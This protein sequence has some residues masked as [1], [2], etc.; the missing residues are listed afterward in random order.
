MPLSPHHDESEYQTRRTR[1]DPQ[2]TAQGWVIVPF[3]APPAPP[4][5]AHH[6]VT[7]YPTANGPADY[8]LFVAGQPLGIV[9]AKK[10]TLGPQNVLIQAERYARG[11]A[12][13][14]FNFGGCRAP[15]L[16]STN[17]DAIWFHDV[18]HLLNRSRRV[19][20]FHTPAALQE[21]LARD[22][23]AACS[24]FADTPNDNP[25]LRPYQVEANAAIEQA[26]AGRK[27][28]MLV[29]MAT[30][31]GKT[32]TLVNQVYR[33]MKSGVARRILFLVDR[34]ALA[35]QAVNAFASFEPE[36][37]LKFD[38]IYEVYSQR[39]RREDL[40]DDAK[41][42]A[43]ALP[44]G[45]LLDPQPGHAF[46]YVCTIQRMA[47]NLFGRQAAFAL[48]DEEADDDADRLAIPIHAFDLIVA[49]ECH[50]GYTSAELS[51]WRNTLEHFDAIK[52]GLT[53]TPAAH[54]KAYFT[55]IIYR[56][57]YERAVREGYLVDFDAVAIKSDVRLSGVF[58][59]EGEQV[60]LIDPETGSEL[61]DRLEDERA[62]DTT[63]IERKVT[64]PDSNR[65]IIEEVKKY[66]LDHEQRTGRFPKTLIFAA[67]DVP[68]VSH[69]DQ[70]VNLCREAFGRGDSFVQKITGSPTVDRPLQRIRE[71]RNR[72]CPAVVVT[73]D[74]LSTGVD[75]PAL[76]FIVFL[77]PIKSRIL[78]EQMLGR[79]TRRCT[80][81]NKSHFTV[82]DCFNGTLL[83]YFR[84]AS[85]F[86]VE[87]PDQPSR[88]VR[89]IIEDV[90]QNRDRPYNVR[91]L[92]KRLQR[93]DKEMSGEAR[94]QFAN[95]IPDG[96]VARLARELPGKVASDF[97]A[98]MRLLRDPAFQ[99]L[100]VNYP[101][102][103]RTFVVAYPT[104]DTVSSTWLIRGADGKEY[105][106]E[107]YLAAFARFVQENPLSIEAVRILLDRP[108]DWST[109]ALAELRQK[110]T[111]TPERFTLDHLEKAHAA[112]YHKNLVDIISMVKHAAR[113]EE[114]LLTAPERVERAFAKISGGRQ[115]TAEQQKWLGR[116]REHLVVGL[117]ID[118]EDFE[119]VPVL[120]DA[121]GWRP[122]DRAFDGQLGELIDELNA[123]VA[124]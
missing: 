98:T 19:A 65:K 80:E 52:V 50:R 94:D 74:M 53:A 72:P 112:R 8:A 86:T 100:L 18:R 36:P 111:T 101:R 9:E 118:R 46:V 25:L 103:R 15:F 108:R 51:I 68:H 89:E 67:N 4:P 106:P 37:G 122:A 116:I 81:I 13:S 97:T 62:F 93:I 31:T 41:F 56:Y 3:H 49:D 30:G 78:W 117:S 84:K 7:E 43:K 109:D 27:R 121:G 11:L 39:F 96:D 104:E 124:A 45:Y 79:G 1:I 102:P 90:W 32:Y 92:V 21:M 76:E 69:A 38:K 6:A 85:A 2:L 113:E 16:Y 73:V 35:A 77:R 99:D 5:Y 14:P 48:G 59:Q 12:D 107:D 33:L 60:G 64:S 71:F 44:A 87:P 42:D 28:Q 55:D 63:E 23:D 83:E 40:G 66:A 115:F 22:F 54:T 24:W 47:I 105:K 75:I 70:L 120:L 17:G 119:N 82:F 114:P 10:L 20:A 58:L 57:E 95:F 26:I 110:L 88:T 29:A 91:C 61:L 123:A 34:R